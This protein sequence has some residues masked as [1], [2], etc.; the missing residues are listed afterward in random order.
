MG[1]ASA[2]VVV[3]GLIGSALPPQQSPPVPD[4]S[5]GL[6]VTYAD[7]RVHTQPLRAK[8]GYWTTNFPKTVG[9]IPAHDGLPVYAIHVMYVADGRDVVVTVS[10]SY[11]RTTQNQMK[12]G[13]FRVT[14]S[15]SVDVP[16]LRT[17]G[18][19]PISLSIITI[20]DRRPNAPETVSS[21]PMLDI[22]AEQSGPNASS[23]RVTVTN[24]SEVPL[25]WI[26]TRAYRDGRPSTGARRGKHGHPLAEP[27]AQY[28]FDI[29]L[30][31]TGFVPGN[32]APAWSSVDRIEVP[33]L[34]W[35]DGR[36]EGDINVAVSQAAIDKRRS[37]DL[38]ILIDTLAWGRAQPAAMLR[39]RLSSAKISSFDV[40]D[41]IKGLT[42]DLDALMGTG[43]SRDDL[44][45]DAWIA[46]AIQYHE[47]WLNRIVL[48]KI[49]R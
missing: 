3:L 28:V 12:V 20:P 29:N 41:S 19:E 5:R 4:T 24:R 8:G 35:Q 11:G 36:V 31:V 32:E 48:P 9:A 18:V 16:E 7:G 22:R 13:D 27:G 15:A 1:F 46:N 42:A 25:I 2:A 43:R 14:P 21:S 37:A 45:F 30:P 47:Q 40:A 10:L 44:P 38:G 34:M 49:S 6:L 33:S 39:A 26:Y 23:Y 17:Y